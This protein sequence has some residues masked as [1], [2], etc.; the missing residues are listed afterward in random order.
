MVNKNEIGTLANPAALADL[1]LNVAAGEEIGKSPV[2]SL[3]E[4]HT[5]AT[6]AF[7]LD[8]E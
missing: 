1:L 3:I 6:E 2:L 7:G 8:D 5:A 4:L